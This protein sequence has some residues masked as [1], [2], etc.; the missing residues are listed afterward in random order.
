[1][2]S[3]RQ[4]YKKL[5]EGFITTFE[6]YKKDFQHPQCFNPLMHNVPK[7]SDRL[8]KS[9]SICCKIFKVCLTILGHYALKGLYAP[10]RRLATSFYKV[11]SVPE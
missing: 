1:M 6:K 9:C 11:I 4:K 7:W 8:L 2:T 10:L 5:F 3:L